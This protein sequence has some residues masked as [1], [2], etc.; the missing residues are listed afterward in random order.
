M[1]T[2][3]YYFNDSLVLSG[4]SF[5]TGVGALATTNGMGRFAMF[6]STARTDLDYLFDNIQVQV[7]PEPATMGMLLL[8]AVTVLAVRRRR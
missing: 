5:G 3:D 7:I 2:V 4:A 8:G 6:D 1:N